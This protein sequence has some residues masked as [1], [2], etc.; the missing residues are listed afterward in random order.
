MRVLVVGQHLALVE[1]A[2]LAR[3][4]TCPFANSIHSFGF[5]HY[6]LKRRN[7]RKADQVD[8]P[9]CAAI[10][11]HDAVVDGS[12]V[13]YFVLE[14]FDQLELRLQILLDQ[15]VLELFTYLVLDR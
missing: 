7:I 13:L 4:H 6:N 10:V 9:L 8:L 11:P 3:V 1:L 2:A 15:R 5:T 14:V 12:N